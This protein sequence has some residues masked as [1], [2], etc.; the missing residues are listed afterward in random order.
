MKEIAQQL[1]IPLGLDLVRHAI[2]LL[3]DAKHP[4]HPSK[5]VEAVKTALKN[6]VNKVIHAQQSN[7]EEAK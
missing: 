2:I 1:I 4:D 5:L 3:D 7:I 6:E